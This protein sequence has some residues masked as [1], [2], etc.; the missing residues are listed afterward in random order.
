MSHRHKKPQLGL[1]GGVT[2]APTNICV[3]QSVLPRNI[4]GTDTVAVV[5]KKHLKFKNAYAFGQVR[6][7]IVMKALKQL[8]KTTLYKL[9]NVAIDDNSKQVFIEN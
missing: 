1:T 3:I 6:V 8:C 4:K 9:E 2:N 7:H 5:L